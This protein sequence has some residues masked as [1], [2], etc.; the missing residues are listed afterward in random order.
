MAFPTPYQGD[1]KKECVSPTLQRMAIAI[2]LAEITARDSGVSKSRTF[3][4]N[5]NKFLRDA[6]SKP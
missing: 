2:A 6:L 5:L 1:F 4:R 3:I